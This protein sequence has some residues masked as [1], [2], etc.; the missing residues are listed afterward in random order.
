MST[1][2][3]TLEAFIDRVGGV[4]TP[5]SIAM[6]DGAERNIGSGAP[7]FHVDLHNDRALKAL[8]TLDEADIAEAYLQGDIDIEGD[9]L[10]PFALRES[11]DDK[12]PLVTA[13][14]FIQPAL[15]G[16]VYTNKKAIASTTI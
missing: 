15:F 7:A 16:Q 5:F 3:T 6:P 2:A 12:H 1:A 13:W 4:A 10:Q 9:M 8:R 14:R 11:L